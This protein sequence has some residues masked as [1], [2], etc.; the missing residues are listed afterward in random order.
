MNTP[1]EVEEL[2]MS[3]ERGLQLQL[4]HPLFAHLAKELLSLFDGEGAVNY[5]EFSVQTEDRGPFSVT[6][7]RLEGETP[8]QVNARLQAEIGRLRALA[9]V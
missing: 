3:K 4:R 1:I 5:L 2:H 9:G 6:I 8:A 7:Q